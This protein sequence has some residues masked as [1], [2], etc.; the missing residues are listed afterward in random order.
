MLKTAWRKYDTGGIANAVIP[1][2]HPVDRQGDASPSP[3]I[4]RAFNDKTRVTMYAADAVPPRPFVRNVSMT[5][6]IL[7]L[8]Q[9]CCGERRWQYDQGFVR[10]PCFMP[11]QVP[12]SA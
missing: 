7:P 9:A 11:W 3:F 4:R 5:P 8:Q 12:G 6:W 10:L 1:E 2:A